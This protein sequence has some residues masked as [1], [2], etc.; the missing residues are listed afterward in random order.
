MSELD[1]FFDKIHKTD[2]CWNWIGYITNCGYGQFKKNISAHRFS[3]KF[4]IGEIPKGMYVLHKCDNRICVN[5]DHLFIGTHL[6]NIKDM[7]SKNR[8]NISGIGKGEN[9]GEKCGNAKLNEEIVK[10][11]RENV[12]LYKSQRSLAKKLNI[13]FKTLN[14]IISRKTWKHI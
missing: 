4:H 7:N 13:P 1:L 6:D 9:R 3:Y 8:G 2:Y 5:P 12:S 10:H 14:D 11:I